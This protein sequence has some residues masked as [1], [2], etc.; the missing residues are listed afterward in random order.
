MLSGVATKGITRKQLLRN[1]S[2]ATRRDPTTQSCFPLR[3]H[4]AV[5]HKTVVFTLLQWPQC[6]EAASPLFL[7]GL[8]L[9]QASPASPLGP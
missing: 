8:Q 2:K 4:K 7:P 3:R 9:T 5:P 1:F 6:V